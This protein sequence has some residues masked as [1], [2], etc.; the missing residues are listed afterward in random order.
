MFNTT[1]YLMHTHKACMG[2]ERCGVWAQTFHLRVRDNQLESLQ[3]R[4]MKMRKG[5]EGKVCEQQLRSRGL[6]SKSVFLQFIAQ[7][8]PGNGKSVSLNCWKDSY[9]RTVGAVSQ[10]SE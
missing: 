8:L 2:R 4:A 6:L 9:I 1:A 5:L 7:V 3:R 10:S